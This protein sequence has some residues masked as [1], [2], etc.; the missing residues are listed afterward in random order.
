[1]VFDSESGMLACPSCN[2]QENIEE[3]PEQ[4][5]V[6]TF[7]EEETKE[8]NCENCGA[9]LITEVET[10]ATMCS[11]CGA[12]VVI[13][14][15]VTA[16]L[17]PTKVLPFKISKAEAQRAFQKWCRN[18]LLTPKG[19]MTADRIKNITGMYVPFWLY[20]LNNDV[21]V[22][23]VCTKVRTY[24]RGDYI[25]TE[26]RYYKAYRHLNLDYLKVPVDASEKMD[27]TLMDRLEPFPYNE[28]KS[29]KTPYLA[30]FIAEKYNYDDEELFPRAK[31]KISKYIDSYIRSTFA[32]Y[33]STSIKNKHIKTNNLNSRY[34][35]L[36]VWIVVYDF[37]KMEHTFAMNGQTGK[38]VGKPP[39]SKRKVAYWFSGIASSTLLILKIA[40]FA[41]GGGFW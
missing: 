2:R 35:L 31:Q 39:I 19:F 24:T 7:S 28:L 14:D 8:Y 13:A 40:S 6:S 41:M 3:L 10:V 23:A 26:T 27:D 9:V 34:V 11:F 25:Y 21:K 12:G 38:I 17:A 22:D 4:Y 33:S 1:M 36:P 15:R 16:D 37:N 32:N 18:G 30:G 5:I 29:F 20:D